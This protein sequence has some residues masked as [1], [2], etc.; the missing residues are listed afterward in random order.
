M[1]RP[2]RA[3][4]SAVALLARW[5]LAARGVVYLC[6]GLL[7][8]RVAVHAARRPVDGAG[9][10]RVLDMP[11][12]GR[13]LLVLAAVGLLGYAIYNFVRAVFDI[14]GDGAHLAGLFTRLGYVVVGGSYVGLAWGALGLI[15]GFSNGGASSD[16]E[17][18]SWTARTLAMPFG[19]AAI[20][21]LGL[22]LVVVALAQCYQAYT[23]TFARRLS[24]ATLSRLAKA[25]V[26]LLGRAAVLARA[27][28]LG[29]IGVFLTRAALADNARLARGMAGALTVLS[30]HQYGNLVLGGV[31]AGFIAYG[32]YSFVEVRYRDIGIA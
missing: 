5:G 13:V 6:M 25:A 27:V 21:L 23:F 8:V 14:E 17:A 20:L 12:F 4:R 26:Q 3:A 30:R 2:A 32:L 31:A 10:L 19:D 28:V 9:V 1:R 16:V 7:A 22:I 29:V 15:V 18:R 11:P 24:L